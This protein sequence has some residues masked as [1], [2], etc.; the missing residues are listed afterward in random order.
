MKTQELYING[1]KVDLLPDTE[2]ALVFQNINFGELK[3]TGSGSQTVKIPITANNSFIFEQ[4]QDQTS[5]SRFMY[6]IHNCNYYEDGMLV[7]E[8]GI[9]YVLCVTDRVYEICITFGNAPI[10]DIMKQT[11]MSDVDLGATLT[12]EDVEP[13]DNIKFL[14]IEAG[15]NDTKR[16]TFEKGRDTFTVRADGA[17][18][19]G[20]MRNYFSLDKVIQKIGEKLGII[21]DGVPSVFSSILMQNWATKATISKFEWEHNRLMSGYSAESWM[22]NARVYYAANPFYRLKLPFIKR[23]LP[24]TVPGMDSSMTSGI[25]IPQSGNYNI[26]LNGNIQVTANATGVRMQFTNKDNSDF[27]MMSANNYF[28][29]NPALFPSIALGASGGAFDNQWNN[30]YLEQGF[31]YLRLHSTPI[32]GGG[33]Y[34][35]INFTGSQI[36]ISISQSQPRKLSFNTPIINENSTVTNSDNDYLDTF[37]EK[38]E[39]AFGE[40]SVFDVLTDILKSFCLFVKYSGNRLTIYSIDDVKNNILIGNVYDWTKNI[41]D[42]SIKINPVNNIAQN[43]A[44]N[45]KPETNYLGGRDGILPANSTAENSVLFENKIFSQSDFGILVHPVQDLRI[46]NNVRLTEQ[47]GV[48]NI[49]RGFNPAPKFFLRLA[50]NALGFT[51]SRSGFSPNIAA[52]RVTIGTNTYFQQPITAFWESYRKIIERPKIITLR[53]IFGAEDLQDF[54]FAKPV[55]L[56]QY[57]SYYLLQKI[58]G[59]RLGQP[60]EVELL[61]MEQ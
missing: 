11:P 12:V 56:R 22:L 33:A 13:S 29:H 54:D 9:L 35:V 3:S 15:V 26:R 52:G 55:Y 30:Y 1:M 31:Y 2:V 45:W 51:A 23:V 49:D 4:C 39:W 27:L 40:A 47:D 32:L 14:G 21:I 34:P 59:H 44:L 50:E 42:Y 38:N 37:I 57:N 20:R 28:Q 24:I 19:S 6:R 36:N 60:C 43:N 53:M 25:Y 5:D 10:F 41:F 61:K 58:N 16:T 48:V 7:V 46:M 17:I 18:R 8:N